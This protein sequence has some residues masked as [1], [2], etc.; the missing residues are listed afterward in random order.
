MN[1]KL[2]ISESQLKSI[3]NYI[4]ESEK[5]LNE[6]FK[7]LALC[8]L[9]LNGKKLSGQNEFI[10]NESLKNP[11][12]LD[13]LDSILSDMSKLEPFLKKLDVTIPNSSGSIMNNLGTI[14]LNL[15]KNK[16]NLHK[17]K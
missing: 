13:E 8:L 4:L 1:K 10:A 17:S 15:S 14:L 16:K 11:Q 5:M 9:H 3:A 2:I 12:I 7:D 6:N